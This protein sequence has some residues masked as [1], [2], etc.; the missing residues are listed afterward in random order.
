M[1]D[2]IAPRYDLLN[3]LLSGRRDAAW[4]RV[5]I[6][7]ISYLPRGRVVDVATGTGDVLLEVARRHPEL[8]DLIGIDLSAEML[9]VAREKH[10]AR[11]GDTRLR[12]EQGEAARLSLPDALADV[13]TIAFGLRN[14]VEREQAL[15]EFSR[16]L[17]DEGMLLILEFFEPPP[18]IFSK[19]YNWYFKHVLPR[20]G[21]MLS[22]PSAYSYLPKSVEGFVSVPTLVGE[23]ERHQL[24]LEEERRFLFGACRL[25]RA[26]RLARS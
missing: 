15:G 3:A 5:M 11:G 22:D 8:T 18:G 7:A 6:D 21:G 10:A 4:R 13:V 12:F 1:F 20:L 17:K 23:M 26:R 24:A 14:V 19:L 25:L 16:V 9:R 2:R